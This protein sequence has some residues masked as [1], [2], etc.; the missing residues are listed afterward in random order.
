MTIGAWRPRGGTKNRTAMLVIGVLVAASALTACG[1]SDSDGDSGSGEDGGGSPLE[2]AKVGVMIAVGESEALQ[3]WNETAVTALESQGIEVVTGDGQGKPEVW[4]Q[5]LD[6]FRT[7]NVKAVITVGGYAPATVTPQLQALKEAGI[8]VVATSNASEDP[9]G[10]VTA[11]YSASDAKLGE[12]VAEYLAETLEPGSEYVN[13]NVPAAKAATDFIDASDE[14]LQAAGMKLVGSTDMDPAK[15]SYPQQAADGAVNL[16]RANPGVAAVVSCC[17]FTPAAT[18]P[19]L[20]QAGFGDVIQAA[21]YDNLSTLK[22]ISDGAPVVVSAANNDT[23]VLTGVEQV[24][25]YI[26]DGTPIDP[27]LGTDD[28][29]T[30]DVVTA[31]NVPPE[32]DYFYDPQAQIDEFVAK[33]ETEFAS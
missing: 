11:S 14:I 1:D 28:L 16:L 8:P 21:R 10:L 27:A 9:E 20:E 32:G 19:A 5:I 4:G 6:N 2:G 12:V 22:L 31:E 30:F 15:G 18:A 29:Y 26:Y 25:K 24:L 13:L 7:Q 17:D 23:G 3:H 33:W